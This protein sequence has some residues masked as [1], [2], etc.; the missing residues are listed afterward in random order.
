MNNP[1]ILFRD[2]PMN[3]LDPLGRT[4]IK[5]LMQELQQQGKTILF[6]THILPDVQQ[7]ASSYGILHKWSIIDTGEVSSITG[8]LEDRF[9]NKIEEHTNTHTAHS[10]QTKRHI[11]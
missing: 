10:D 7:V 2:E 8:S 5:N 11:Q 3:G 1:A 6:S 4:L 9:V